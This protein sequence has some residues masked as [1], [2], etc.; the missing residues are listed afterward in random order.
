MIDATT[1][2]TEALI[3]EVPYLTM[4]EKQGYDWE[5][6]GTLLNLHVQGLGPRNSAGDEPPMLGFQ[7][8]PK[9]YWSSVKFQIFELLCTDNE[10]YAETRKRLTGHTDTATIYLL[11]TLSVWLATTLSTSVAMIMPLVGTVLYAIAKLG[12]GAW[13]ELRQKPQ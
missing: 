6:L 13:C 9:D 8:A 10:K 12:L 4:I 7:I 5:Q 2:D 3:N 11:S 1:I